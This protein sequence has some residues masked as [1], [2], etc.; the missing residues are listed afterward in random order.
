MPNPARRRREPQSRRPRKSLANPFSGVLGAVKRDVD[1]RLEAVLASRIEAARGF[2][3]ELSTMLE[4]LASLSRRGGKRLRPALVVAGCRAVTPRYDA[5][6]ALSAGVALELIQS[7]FLIHDDWMDG[8]LVRRGGPSVHAA[9]NQRFDDAHKAE[10]SAILAG[11]YAAALGLDVLAQ[12]SLP[13]AVSAKIFASFARLQLDAV[14]GQHLDLFA[15]A[16]DPEAAYALKTGSYTVHGPLEIGAQLAGGKPATLKALAKFARPLGIAFQLR[17]DLLGAFGDPQKTGKPLGNDLREGKRTLLLL[18][19]L[20]RSKPRERASIERVLGNPRARELD[21]RRAL[22]VVESSG[23]RARVE[24]RIHELAHEARRALAKGV[25][26]DGV[27]LLTGAVE[28][29]TER[30]Y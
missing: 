10:A 30:P 16:P 28:I 4:A 17:D 8:D 11:D 19:T 20:S 27:E 18:E 7:Y 22:A 14:L 24:E 21:L 1:R 2:G 3:P 6:L 25:S 23:A 29:L 5:E 12:A 13:K 26:A 9:L 15:T